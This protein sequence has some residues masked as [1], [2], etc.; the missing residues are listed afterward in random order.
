M[1]EPKRPWVQR[2]EGEKLGSP[3]PEKGAKAGGKATKAAIDEW[4]AEVEPV[5]RD[6]QTIW[7][8]HTGE[9]GKGAGSPWRDH[10]PW[11]YKLGI[12]QFNQS[13]KADLMKRQLD[14]ERY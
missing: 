7:M 3:T 1:R 10:I 2:R 14:D 12:E 9:T 4:S 6:L 5:V 8:R 13:L 11:Q